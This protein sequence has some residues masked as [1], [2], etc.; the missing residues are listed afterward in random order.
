MK[1]M[2]FYAYER[3]IGTGKARARPMQGYHRQINGVSVYVSKYG[4]V[5]RTYDEDSGRWMTQAKTMKGAIASAES[6]VAKADSF[7][8]F[9]S[10]QYKDYCREFLKLR[11]EAANGLL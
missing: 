5:W 9:T 4:G 2:T 6:Y 10:P 8:G 1:Q 3:D 7:G 11:K